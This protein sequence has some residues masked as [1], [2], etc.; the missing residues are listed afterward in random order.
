M[1]YRLGVLGLE[2]RTRY[3][4]ITN[5][6]LIHGK[7]RHYTSITSASRLCW[8][9]Y[10]SH[11]LADFQGRV[12][13][14]SSTPIRALDAPRELFDG[15]ILSSQNTGSRRPVPL[16]EKRLSGHSQSWHD[17]PRIQDGIDDPSRATRRD[18]IPRQLH[19][20]LHAQARSKIPT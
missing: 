10:R 12:L 1:H 3:R 2:L 14:L 18:E 4:S 17:R 5:T 7:T 11:F 6:R 20:R 9:G 16:A 19:T 13:R 8:I 15:R